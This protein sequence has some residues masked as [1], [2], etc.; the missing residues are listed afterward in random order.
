MQATDYFNG[1]NR[2]L[3]IPIKQTRRATDVQG[4]NQK[5]DA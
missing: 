1:K 4:H 2:L 3:Q 5:M